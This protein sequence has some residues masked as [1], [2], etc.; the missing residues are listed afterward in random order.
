MK[1][2]HI[3]AVLLA[4]AGAIILAQ[5]A[6]YAGIF[7][8]RDA[9]SYVSGIYFMNEYGFHQP[10]PNWDH[11]FGHISFLMY[12]PMFAFLSVPV[13][14]MAGSATFAYAFLLTLF[15]ILM[16]LLLY[17]NRKALGLDRTKA[18]LLS[19]LFIF[20]P[21]FVS[22]MFRTGRLPELVGWFFFLA[23]FLIVMHYRDRKIDKWFYLFGI[24]YA[25]AILSHPLTALL[26]SIFIISLL[27]SKI[28]ERRAREVLDIVAASLIG[29]LLC[30]FWLVPFV[31]SYCFGD[32]SFGVKYSD[33]SDKSIVA[34]FVNENGPLAG[35]LPIYAII[36]VIIFLSLVFIFLKFKQSKKKARIFLLP[37][38]AYEIVFMTWLI[39]DSLFHVD[40]PIISSAASGT[41]LVFIVF[42]ASYFFLATNWG[43]YR[44]QAGTAMVLVCLAMLAFTAVFYSNALEKL[45][46]RKTGGFKAAELFPLVKGTYD[47][48]PVENWHTAVAYATVEYGLNTTASWLPETAPKDLTD[49]R[50]RLIK[51]VQSADCQGML[52]A[53]KT[54]GISYL[55]GQDAD[56]TSMESCGAA[57]SGAIGGFCLF[58][59]PAAVGA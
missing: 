34:S 51:S 46:Y 47:I 1:Y 14:A 21:I 13:Y 59:F 53:T 5:T 22:R 56:C 16:L 25:L 30:S 42:L 19:L 8:I 27:L 37:P 40:V 6:Q 57:K 4:V 35:K 9:S 41:Q 43:R 33:T 10:V 28:Y 48:M 18:I 17:F 23:C 26:L 2:L 3:S 49:L 38:M 32:N 36:A 11:G 52:N 54:L 29:L 31:F 12:P 39:T 20:N 15:P 7:P 50:E 58:R 45:D 55:I 44:K 24:F